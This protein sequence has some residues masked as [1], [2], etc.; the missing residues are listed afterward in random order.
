MASTAINVGAGSSV[1][2]RLLA[3]TAVAV[4]TCDIALTLP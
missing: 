1:N 2:G 4:D 3:K